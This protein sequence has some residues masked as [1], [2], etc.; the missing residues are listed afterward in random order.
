MGLNLEH[1]IEWSNINLDGEK[2]ISE[3]LKKIKK[4]RVKDFLKLKFN[5]VTNR[6]I[7]IKLINQINS[8]IFKS[9]KTNKIKGSHYL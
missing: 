6:T 3:R 7:E 8:A 9:R 4:Y 2:A 1:V 5:N